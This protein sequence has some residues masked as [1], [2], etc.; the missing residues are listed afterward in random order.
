MDGYNLKG[1][2]AKF[3]KQGIFYT[4]TSLAEKIKSYV[5]F[6]PKEVYDPTCGDGALLSVFGD[7]VKKYGQEINSEQLN[8]ARNRLKN[9]SGY[10][11][12]TLKNPAFMDKKFDCIVANYPFSISWTPTIDARFEKAPTIPTASRADY[13]FILH[14]LYLLS[15]DGIAVT[16][17]FPGVLYR[18]NREGTIRK[19]IIEQNFI[20]RV[21]H[22][23]GNTFVDTTIATAIIVF[24]KNKQTTDIIFESGDRQK[25]VT[26]EEVKKNGFS[27]AVNNYIFDE[28]KKTELDPIEL[29]RQARLKF[30]KK[31]EKELAFSQMVA[32]MEN[33]EFGD[34]LDD[35]EKIVQAFRS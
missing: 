29:E 31:I 25:I 33:I 28:V 10:C 1:I 12:D 15:D 9:F 18:G 4:P 23:E 13:A 17:N 20:E 7:E 35:I 24:R 5:D 3:K 21:V 14:I 27:L 2:K 32:K 26:L 30:L 19:W 11:G 22:I 16:L 6:V 34:L 8:A